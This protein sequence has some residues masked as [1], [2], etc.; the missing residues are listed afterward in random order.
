MDLPCNVRSI[1]AEPVEKAQMA[2][3]DNFDTFKSQQLTDQRKPQNARFQGFPTGS[4]YLISFPVT[5]KVSICFLYI[6]SGGIISTSNHQSLKPPS[7][8]H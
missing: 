4:L 2:N 3:S 8:D 7:T 6:E 1:G 5:E